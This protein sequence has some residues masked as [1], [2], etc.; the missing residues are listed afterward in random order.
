M[1]DIYSSSDIKPG[2][3]VKILLTNPRLRIDR[4]SQNAT[5]VQRAPI[6]MMV[7]DSQG[8]KFVEIKPG[9]KIILKSTM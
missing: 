6:T 7:V 8:T 2:T 3:M 9:T 1:S 5:L 4:S